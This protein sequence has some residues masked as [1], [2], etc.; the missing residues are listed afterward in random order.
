MAKGKNYVYCDKCGEEYNTFGP[1]PGHKCDPKVLKQIERDRKA[2]EEV[3]KSGNGWR[4][5]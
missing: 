4:Q 5:G 1:G 2:D 3:R